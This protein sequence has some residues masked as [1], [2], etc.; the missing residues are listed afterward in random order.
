MLIM[1]FMHASRRPYPP[2]ESYWASNIISGVGVGS[3]SLIKEIAKGVGGVVYEPYL[4]VNK[5]GIKGLP[6]G[7]VKGIGGL[8]G[9][10]VKGVFDFVAQ[11]VV[12]AFNTPSYIYNKLT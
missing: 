2:Q 12:G 11:P 1:A 4:E 3:S 9:R 8:V 6:F 5:Y 10:P 7:F